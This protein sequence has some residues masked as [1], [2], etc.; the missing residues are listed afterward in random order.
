MKKLFG[1]ADKYI[2]QSDWRELAMIKFCLASM[3]IVTGASLLEKQRKPAMWIVVGVFA[4]I[5][6]P[7]IA[8]LLCVVTERPVPE[9]EL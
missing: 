3:G 9:N 8:K 7:L 5:F 4:A 2:K 6:L 1:Y